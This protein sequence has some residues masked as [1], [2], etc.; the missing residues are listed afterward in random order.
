MKNMSNKNNI[1]MTIIALLLVIV[2]AAGFTYSWVE[3]GASGY[4]KNESKFLTVTTGSTLMM[5]DD[6]GNY[7]DS[8]E[9]SNCNLQEV[10]SYDGRN[11]FIPMEY[12]TSNITSEM[13]FREGIPT[14]ENTKYISCDFTLKA[15]DKETDVYLGAGTAIQLDETKNTYTR[16]QSKA[17]LNALRLSFTTDKGEVWVFKPSQ[18][19][20]STDSYAPVVQ[21][22]EV[23]GAYEHSDTKRSTYPF[24]DYYYK[25]D[26]KDDAGNSVSK[27]L[28]TLI[29]NESKNIS[30][31][32]W[33]EGTEVNSK[34]IANIPLKINIDFTTV[35]TDLVKYTFE[36]NTHGFSGAQAEY[37]ITNTATNSNYSTMM[38]LFDVD[39]Q[40][41]YAM[42]K[43]KDKTSNS[44]S[45]WIVYVPNTIDRFYFRRYSIDIDTY[46]NQWEP[47]M[48]SGIVKDPDDEY[49]YVAICGKPGGDSEEDEGCYGYWRDSN[50]TIRIY[51]EEYEDSTNWGQVLCKVWH[52]APDKN[53]NG[54]TTYEMTWLKNP[55]GDTNRDL[56]CCNIENGRYIT[57]LTFT[58]IDLD[59]KKE[60]AKEYK[61]Y[62]DD[63]QYYFNG[64]ATW[65]KNFEN[66]GKV[67]ADTDNDGKADSYTH[68]VYTDKD[69][70]LIYPFNKPEN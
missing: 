56:W 14:D 38:Y 63:T 39:A 40:R 69:D 6:A 33:L 13:Y 31:S 3:G 45:E 53:L 17:L 15:G 27:S 2:L 66:C 35:T 42:T 64:F 22:D 57:G 54:E 23:T 19:P 44:G 62:S 43:D 48:G 16:E 12:N 59:T 25:G 5:L 41:Y 32:I 20:G 26:G 9:L 34:D 10:S 51:I 60:S 49:T 58:G 67:F 61:F 7:T 50:D 70:S 37:W 52:Y 18:M 36:D 30:L 46:W 68:W 55:D 47:N 28:F 1:I 11:F 24:G 21:L 8:I 29:G 4:V 65:Y